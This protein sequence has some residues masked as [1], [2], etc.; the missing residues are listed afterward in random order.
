MPYRALSVEKAPGPGPRRRGIP[1][2]AADGRLH[3]VAVPRVRDGLVLRLVFCR[4][5][6]I[7][8][9]ACDAPVR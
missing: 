4:S 1:D 5:A 3:A 9:P 2:W 8:R 6:V 7:G